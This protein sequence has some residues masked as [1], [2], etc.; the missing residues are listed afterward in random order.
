MMTSRRFDRRFGRGHA[1]ARFVAALP[2][3]AFLMVPAVSRA[4]A[5]SAKPDELTMAV[6]RYELTMDVIEA[7]GR[8]MAGLATWA[9]GDPAAAAALRSRAPK[10]STKSIKSAVA[11]IE[12][13]AVVKGR[14]NEQK[15]SSRDFLL[16][17]MVVMQAQI[18]VLG[19]S[20]GRTF[21]PD[22][23]N[24]KNVALV[25]ANEARINDVMAKIA[26]DRARAFGR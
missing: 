23:I 20:Q 14:L 18:A 8:V 12:R 2:L 24:P 10:T 3:C 5:S 13:E 19:E 9:E 25:R 7:Y 17:P 4:Q 6:A 1:V 16:L 22:R 15:I 11:Q 26:A 21:P